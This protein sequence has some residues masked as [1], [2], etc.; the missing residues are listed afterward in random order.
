MA[1]LGANFH[2]HLVIDKSD[3]PVGPGVTMNGSAVF[4][5]PV[6]EFTGEA[7]FDNHW[8]AGGNGDLKLEVPLYTFIDWQMALGEATAGGK[9]TADQQHVYVSGDIDKD[10]PWKPEGLPLSLDYRNNY[11][12]ARVLREQRGS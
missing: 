3:I 9:V 11:Q 4:K 12:V 8:Q 5:F 6:D 1:A 10:F 2:G 7:Q